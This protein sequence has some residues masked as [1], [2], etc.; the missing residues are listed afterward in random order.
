[1]YTGI[2]NI[3]GMENETSLWN[4]LTQPAILLAFVAA[5]CTL[6]YTVINWKLLIESRKTRKQKITPQ[7]IAFLKSSE[8]HSVLALHIKNIGEGLAKNVKINTIKDHNIMQKDDYLISNAGIFKNGF[9][10]FPPQYELRFH[11]D[12]WSKIKSGQEDGYVE[13]EI[14]YE[15]I[16]GKKYTR[17][18]ELPFNQLTGQH[19][20]NPPET[21]MGQIPYYLSEIDKKLKILSIEDKTP[22]SKN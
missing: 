15:D 17:S 2:F 9:N 11:L 8:S 18:F 14:L 13:V 12:W 5:L 4:E 21:Y 10:I 6:A 7:I 1:M 16:E 3:N 20:T 19:Y 22:N